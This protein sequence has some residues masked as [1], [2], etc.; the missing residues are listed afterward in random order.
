M[1]PR[2]RGGDELV[3]KWTRVRGYREAINERIEPLRRDKRIRSSLEAELWV[4]VDGNEEATLL[5]S[6]DMAEVAIVSAAQVS[7]NEKESFSLPES[8][9]A[10]EFAVYIEV[11][12]TTHHK[13]GRCWRHLP[14]VAEDGGLCNRC[15]KVLSAS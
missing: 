11:T 13:C 2:I 1:D 7:A 9:D 10:N 3:E 14:E 5:K 12:P 4:D 15:D 6:V 8:S